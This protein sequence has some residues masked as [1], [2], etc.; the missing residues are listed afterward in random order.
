MIYDGGAIRP[1]KE[2]WCATCHD[3]DE[4]S[5]EEGVLIDDFEAYT[6][7][8]TLRANWAKAQDTKQRFL[9]PQST[10]ITGP[11][12]SQCMRVKINWTNNAEYA[13]GSVIK[14]YTPPVDLTDMDAVNLYVKVSDPLKIDKIKVQLR[15][16]P[17]ATFCTAS[18]N[19]Y[20]LHSGG[21][22]WTKVTLPRA[23]FNDTTWGLVD[24]IR[25]RILEDDPNGSH[26][27]YVYFDNIYFSKG[28][29]NVIGDNQ[30]Y[31]YYITGHNFRNCTWCHDPTSAH[32]DGQRLPILEYIKNTPN[33]TN[34]RFYDDSTKQIR[35]PYNYDNTTAYNSDDFALCYQCH[36]ETN[37]IGDPWGDGTNFKD[38]NVGTCQMQKNY[39]Y[40]HV[41]NFADGQSGQSC[42]HCHDPHGQFYPA[43]TRKEM[44]EAIVFDTGGCEI[45]PGDD[46]DGGGVD[47]RHDPD[48]NAGVALQSDLFALGDTCDSCHGGFGGSI[49]PPNQPPCNPEDNPYTPADC[50]GDW[51]YLRSYE[52]V[53][54]TGEPDIAC[55]E[56]HRDEGHATHF[57]TDGKGPGMAE[58]NDG[59]D[60]CHEGLAPGLKDSAC[61]N[62]HSDG[63]AFDGAQMALA[64]W[65]S[66]VY[67]ED[68]SLKSGNEDWCL[69]CHD[70][71]QASSNQDGSGQPAPD[72]GGDNSTYGF[73]AMGHGRNTEYPLMYFQEGSGNGNPGAG[74]V[75]TDCH[76]SASDHV[77]GGDIA[78]LKSG[79]E[80]NQSNEN[81]NRCHPPG[82]SATADPQLYTNS[83]EYEAADHG[84]WLCTSC[85]DVH[86]MVA[87]A[88]P[89][90]ATDGKR[91]LCL[92]CHNN[93][94]PNPPSAPSEAPAEHDQTSDA[95]CSTCHNPHMP[96]HGG[97]EPDCFT[98]GCHA[99]NQMHAAHFYGEDGPSFPVNETGCYYCHADARVQCA[100][101]AL[102][103]NVEDPEGPPQVLS[104]TTVCD[105]CHT[106]GP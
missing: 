40:L 82:S 12:G 39:H 106:G 15:K 5:P 7:D 10:G 21:D 98:S 72:M 24:K 28:G 23:S 57:D 20:Q 85:H 26:I 2:K 75:C 13:Y 51:S 74:L 79:Y 16:Y 59:C 71:D 61:D 80:N 22:G 38:K 68:G 37:L 64:N 94:G 104:E 14:T 100:D 45:L 50:L 96:A 92:S 78:R 6:D 56:C 4:Y 91:P 32:I 99:V 93:N 18:V 42:A 54:H 48:V 27:E 8:V 41:Y 44:G 73:N 77:G 70:A 43:M 33:P 47:D 25:I 49:T 3:E 90:M 35:L 66:G 65:D 69:S 9:E 31:G 97:G 103:K 105:S 30:T 17:E 53:P 87:G 1:G 89:A 81:C 58:D 60:C 29:P 102:F 55:M 101:A 83:S 86:G 19:G 88:Y 34:F 52:T 62:C 67:E 11:D 63:G 46:S 36:S 95:A 84:N 76:D